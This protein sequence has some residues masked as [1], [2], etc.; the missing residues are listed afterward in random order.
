MIGFVLAAGFGTRLRPLTD[1]IPKAMVSVCGVPL[2]EVGLRYFR[3]AGIDS[4]G[5]NLHYHGDILQMYLE[6]LPYSISLFHEV[7]DILG[8]GGAIYN[9]RDF[10]AGQDSFAV[11]NTDIV[12]DA[13]L[14]KL[15]NDFLNSDA[16]VMLICQKGGKSPSVVSHKG[17][18]CGVAQAPFQKWSQKDSFIGL[19]LYKKEVLDYFTPRDFSVVDVWERIARSGKEV[20]VRTLDNLY[21]KD[22]GTAGQ[23]LSVYSDILDKKIPFDFPLGMQVDFERKIACADSIPLNLVSPESEY[24]WV[25]RVDASVID[26]ENTVF[27]GGVQVDSARRYENSIIAPWCEVSCEQ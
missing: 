24:V 25:E 6:H 4:L 16:A 9:A 21:W 13:P 7:P 5:V 18:Y 11:L 22:T 10:L 8:T 3:K 20:I 27:L 15:K 2:V 23:L 12:T 1:M 19:A 14:Q 26:A 17:Q